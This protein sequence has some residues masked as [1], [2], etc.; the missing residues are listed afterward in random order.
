MLLLAPAIISQ[1]L[2]R[3]FL[4]AL[5]VVGV[6]RRARVHLAL[7]IVVGALVVV[8]SM[9]G[10]IGVAALLIGVLVTFPYASYVGGYLVGRYARLTESP[11]SSRNAT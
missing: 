7:S 1:Y 11:L 8:L 3:G 10:L 2:D 6:I 5:N 4:G 9:I